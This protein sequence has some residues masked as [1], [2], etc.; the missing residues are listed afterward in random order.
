[1]RGVS[2]SR[3][4]Y[5][6]DVAPLLLGIPHAAGSIGR[7]S[8]AV[9]LDDDISQDHDW[10]DRVTVITE[11]ATPPLPDGVELF[12]LASFV[13]AHLGVDPQDDTDWLLLTGQSV[14]EV[15]AGP[16]F[17]DDNGELT[18]LRSKLQWYP[19]DVERY[20]IA[21]AWR[22]I[23]QELPFIGRTR[24]RGDAQGSEIICARVA[25]NVMHLTFLLEKQWPPYPKW[26][27]TAY[28]TRAP[29]D[30]E[31]AIC[32][33]LDA[34]AGK[35]VTVPFYDR[36]FKTVDPAFLAT[37]PC[38]GIGS[39]EMWIDNVD[40]LSWPERRVQLREV[41]RAWRAL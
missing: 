38:D 10:G 32:A 12:T 25:R 28:G 22:R 5:E 23:D 20:V 9:G 35:P 4:F 41:Y 3:A 39:V 31:E 15:I 24:D 34:L 11:H 26:F 27:G 13:R 16:V 33:A 37:M 1:M 17:R 29:L 2:R 36:P 19:P 7:G 30:S 40:V 8:D 6:R 18:A 14:I 21:C